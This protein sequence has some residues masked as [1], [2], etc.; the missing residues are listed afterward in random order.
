[1]RSN[2][3]DDFQTE[4]AAVDFLHPYIPRK[5]GFVM[6]VVWEPACGKGNLVQALRDQGYVVNG[7]DIKTGHDFMETKPPEGTECIITNPPFSMKDEFLG[8]CYNIGI[9]FALLMPITTFDSIERRSMMDEFGVEVI[10]P[11]RRIKF[12]TPNHEQRIADGKKPLT[13]WFYSAWFTWGFNIG[14]QLVFVRQS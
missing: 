13:A 10:L 3:P 14:S 5:M 6:P 9:P 4:A 2:S 11:P 8:R 7:T 1:M 12:E